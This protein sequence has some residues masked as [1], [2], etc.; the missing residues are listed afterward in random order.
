MTYNRLLEHVRIWLQADLQPP[1]IDFRFDPE[2]GHSSGLHPSEWTVR[3]YR[4][5]LTSQRAVAGVLRLIDLIRGVDGLG[6]E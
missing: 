2:S 6:A 1:E 3:F 4:F 5:G